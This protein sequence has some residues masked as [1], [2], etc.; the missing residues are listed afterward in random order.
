MKEKQREK[1]TSKKKKH[2]TT[3]PQVQ[4]NRHHQLGLEHTTNSTHALSQN[5]RCSPETVSGD[6]KNKK[7]SEPHRIPSL[8]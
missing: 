4:G 2:H 7:K 8:Q 3:E 5:K 6:S 1:Q